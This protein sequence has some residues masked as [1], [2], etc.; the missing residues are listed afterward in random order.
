MEGKLQEL[1]NRLYQEGVEKANSEAKA[2]L[3]KAQ[4]E[5]AA[6]VAKA[7]SEAESLVQ[8]AKNEAQQLKT[9]ALS[10]VKMAGE[11]SLSTV[12][13]EL[14]GLLTQSALN[15][16]VKSALQDG[17]FI[18]SVVKELISKWDPSA[19]LDLNVVLPE[20]SK[21][22]LGDLFK[23]KSADIL[24]KGVELKFEARMEG[25]FRIEPKDGSFILSFTDKDFNQFFQSFLKA[26]SKEILFPGEKA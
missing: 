23:A 16:A 17:A 8:Q 12:K 20:A 11:Q 7:K 2:L 1:T 25:G 22:E 21:K 18:Q 19:P 24:S 14:V 6:L 10:E 3:D 9:K 15:G 26:R 13:Q 5:A 4:K